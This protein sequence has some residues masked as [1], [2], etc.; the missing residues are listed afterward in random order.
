MIVAIVAVLMLNRFGRRAMLIRGVFG[1]FLSLAGLTFGYIFH[2]KESK[3]MQILI[4]CF[5]TAY[6]ISFV[7]TMGPIT[8][9]YIP[10]VVQPPTV[11]YTTMTNWAF[12]SCII[13]LYPIVGEKLG[14]GIF[15]IFGICTLVFF[16]ICLGVM[17]ET[18]N[19]VESEIRN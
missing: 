2:D 1:V 18:K 15:V 10:E 8:W 3:P 11:P 14:A 19:K 6:I 5:F 16:F 13:S 7:L 9:L 17:V 12:A 4:L